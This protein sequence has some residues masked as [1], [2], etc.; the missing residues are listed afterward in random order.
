MVQPISESF[1]WLSLIAAIPASWQAGD[2]RLWIA[3]WPMGTVQVTS[4]AH[5]TASGLGT[6]PLA[7]K[8]CGF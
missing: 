4:A 5:A 6:S 2:S 1:R 3:K 8:G 7:R